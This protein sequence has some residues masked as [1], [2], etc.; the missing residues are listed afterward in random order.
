MFEKLAKKVEYAKTSVIPMCH[1]YEVY[2]Q[3][4]MAH[5]LKAITTEEFLTLNTECVNKVINN[6]LYFNK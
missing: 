1:L 6:P 5:E 3:I 2:G 4:K